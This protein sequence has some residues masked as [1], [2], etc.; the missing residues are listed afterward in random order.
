MPELEA[1][2]REFLVELIRV[3]ET[4]LPLDV[5]NALKKALE[6]EDNPIAKQHLEAILRNSEL[7]A[8]LGKPICQDTG[9]PV[10]YIRLGEEFPLRAK[11]YEVATEAVRE[12]TRLIPLRPN[13]VNPIRGG[14]TG[15]NT[16]RHIPWFD[17]EIVPGDRLEVTFVAKG[18]GS[19]APSTLNMALPIRGIRN[20][21][22]T[23]LKAVVSAGPKPCPPV[24]VGVGI[25]ALGEQALAIARKAALLR[26]LGERHP[27]P[28]IAELEEKLLDA[29]NSLGIGVHG[30]GGK[31]TAL[32]VHID[33]AH[34]HPAT[35]AVGVVFNC[36]AIRRATGYITPDGR[37]EITSKHI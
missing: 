16:G 33:Y 24:V 29:I 31:I 36:W 35:Y 6:V 13:A 14:N 5:Y 15:D 34:R 19:E 17:V 32:D 21:W 7:A 3:A 22:E 37:W 11:I 4:R 12:A 18:G 26:P 9:T 20:V 28:E 1:R 23:V 30:F 27:E 2:L 25:A 10:F 8:K